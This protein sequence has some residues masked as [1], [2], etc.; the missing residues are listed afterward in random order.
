MLASAKCYQLAVA[1]QTMATTIS[2]EE[3]QTAATQIAQC[4]SNVLNVRHTVS[5]FRMTNNDKSQAVNVPL[6]QRGIVLDS[7]SSS[8]NAFP[9]DYDTDLEY[10]W[11]NPSTIV[12]S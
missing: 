3:V 2:F 6:Q 11:A 7:D 1:L 5:L 4:A 12:L 10:A 9:V 8:A